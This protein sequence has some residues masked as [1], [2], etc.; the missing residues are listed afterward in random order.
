MVRKKKKMKK[1]K[2]KMMKA[3]VKNFNCPRNHQMARLN[4]WQNAR[5]VIVKSVQIVFPLHSEIVAFLVW[6]YKRSMRTMSDENGA[7]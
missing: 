4:L 5:M 2:M 3:F 1:M 6:P 7:S